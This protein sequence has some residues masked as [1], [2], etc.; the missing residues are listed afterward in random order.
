MPGRM[1]GVTAPPGPPGMPAPGPPG[2]VVGL[3]PV[4]GGGITGPPGPPG[5]VAVALGV[6]E[7]EVPGIVIGMGGRSV[8]R[9]I[10]RGPPIPGLG[11]VP[12]AGLI[13]GAVAPAAP[14]APGAG[15][16]PGAAS[17][18]FEQEKW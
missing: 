13:P 5:V 4:P 17:R 3:G 1:G 16:V 15:E 8:G 6:G 9:V 12:G 10:G 11:L 7:G 18:T 14:A 2:P